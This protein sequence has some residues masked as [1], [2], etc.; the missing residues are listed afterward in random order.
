MDNLQYCTIALAGELGEM[1]NFVKK[2][3]RAKKSNKEPEAHLFDAMRTELIDVFIYVLIT[4]QVL[5][6]DLE[7]GYFSKMKQNEAKFKQYESKA[8]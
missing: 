4:A 2:V 7:E 3:L 5:G 8:L 6:I 1:A